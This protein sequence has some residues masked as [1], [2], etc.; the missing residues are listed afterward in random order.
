MSKVCS[1]PADRQEVSQAMSVEFDESWARKRAE[2][3][4]FD[5]TFPIGTPHEARLFQIAKEQHERTA[6]NQVAGLESLIANKTLTFDAA[7]KIKNE[8]DA[9]LARIKNLRAA[10]EDI[11]GGMKEKGCRVI[12]HHALSA[13]DAVAGTAP[14]TKE[15]K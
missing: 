4:I 5:K 12:A 8:L 13:D 3:I 9:A 10:L 15:M 6:L 1:K 7:R 11:E 2:E 14:Q